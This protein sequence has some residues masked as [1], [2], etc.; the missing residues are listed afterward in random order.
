MIGLA[1]GAY[2]TVVVF[3]DF[4]ANGKSQAGAV[5]LAKRRKGFE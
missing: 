5:F 2:K 3:D 1:F 4:F